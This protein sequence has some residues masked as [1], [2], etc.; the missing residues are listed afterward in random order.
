MTTTKNFTRSAQTLFFI[1]QAIKKAPDAF[2]LHIAW[3]VW[4]PIAGLGPDSGSESTGGEWNNVTEHCLIA[5]SRGEVLADML[6]F[7]TSLKVKLMNALALHDISK[8]EEVIHAKKFGITWDSYEEVVKNIDIKLREAGFDE[9]TVHL[10]GAM[11]HPSLQ[12]TES[13]LQK[14]EYS[15]YDLAYF[16]A[17][18]CDDI[19]V[20]AGWC[21]PAVTF[22][23]KKINQ[24]DRRMERNINNRNITQLGEEGRSRLNG[25]N[26]FEA[27]REIGHAVEAVLTA[28]LEKKGIT[29][30]GSFELPE[31]VDNELKTKI[32][33]LQK[34]LK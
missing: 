8:P 34:S 2:R 20:K 15:T 22:D 23:G 24:L 16:V 28:E 13:L 3:G 19:S 31:L 25:R 27:Q 4:D 7:P 21:E 30:D 32:E 5:M 12:E 17:H 14:T 1:E 29:L 11:G 18:Y 26:T 6:G 9:E 10:S 33:I